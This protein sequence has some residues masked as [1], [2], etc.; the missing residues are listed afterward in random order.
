[1]LINYCNCYTA[2][3]ADLFNIIGSPTKC[4]DKTTTVGHE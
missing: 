4:I 3:L 1:M 2:A